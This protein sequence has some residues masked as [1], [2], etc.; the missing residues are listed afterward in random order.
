MSKKA[1]EAAKE[2]IK[3]AYKEFEGKEN[4]H[5]SFKMFNKVCHG[6]MLCSESLTTKNERRVLLE[7]WDGYMIE[8]YDSVKK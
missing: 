7:I 1:F 3:T 8:I 2:A 6:I 5:E 4:T